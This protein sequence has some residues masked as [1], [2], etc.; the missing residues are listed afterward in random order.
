[1]T[2]KTGAKAPSFKC[3]D[4]NGVE[5]TLEEFAGKWVV[6]YFY[7]RDNT[8]GCTIEANEFTASCKDFDKRGAVIIGLS[9]D[10]PQSHCGFIEKQKI[11]F[12]LLSDPDHTLLK[13]Y[14][15]WGKKMMYG[16]EVEGVIRSTVLIDPSGRI[17]HHWPKVKAEGHA[18]EVLATLKSLQS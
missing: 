15:G 3:P 6:L 8:P 16:K 14:G 4:Q 9:P 11:N 2:I 13:K 17:A 18:K 5:R 10:S 7:P 12:L 1:M